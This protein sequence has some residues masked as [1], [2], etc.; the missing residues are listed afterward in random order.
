MT[1]S[2]TGGGKLSAPYGW[3]AGRL[4]SPTRPSVG[5]KPWVGRAGGPERKAPAGDAVRVSPRE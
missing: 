3:V 4:T 2:G 1:L 5:R